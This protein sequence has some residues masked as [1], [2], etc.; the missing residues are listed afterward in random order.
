MPE[1]VY[2]EGDRK[3]RLMELLRALAARIRE[4][5]ERGE[6]L[7]SGPELLKLMG[8]ARSELF[9]YEV[10]CTYDS[11]EVAESR[12]IVEEAQRRMEELE[13]S[14]AEPEIY[15]EEDDEPWRSP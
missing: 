15:D 8:D 12:R 10:R 5:D 13:L 2:D 7:A 9:H 6:L 11:P 14:G 4:L 3:A 1:P